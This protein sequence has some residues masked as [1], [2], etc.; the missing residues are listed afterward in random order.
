[1]VDLTDEGRDWAW[2]GRAHME[3]EERREKREERRERER[4]RVCVCVYK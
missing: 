3:R 4:E 2:L 1:M